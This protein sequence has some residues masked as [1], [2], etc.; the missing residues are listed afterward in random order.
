MIFGKDRAKD[1]SIS[2][3]WAKIERDGKYRLAFILMLILVVSDFP[4]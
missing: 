4:E 2:A 1:L 3:E